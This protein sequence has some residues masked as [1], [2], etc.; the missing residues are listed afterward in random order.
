MI[1]NHVSVRPGSPSSKYTYQPVPGDD[2]S[3]EADN[4]WGGDGL[5][6]FGC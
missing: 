2:S 4:F 3:C 5:Q 1:I 6:G